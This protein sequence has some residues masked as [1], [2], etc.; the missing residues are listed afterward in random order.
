MRFLLDAVMAFLSLIF[1]SA[2]PRMS[3]PTWPLS[4]PPPPSSPPAP[5]LTLGSAAISPRSPGA[6]TV[7]SPFTKDGEF[8]GALCFD[9]S[10]KSADAEFGNRWFRSSEALNSVEKQYAIFTDEPEFRSFDFANSA[11]LGALGAGAYLF[12]VLPLATTFEM[13]VLLGYFN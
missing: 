4:P 6:L 9:V 1:W 5:Q 8:H 3:A 12:A 10:P 11:I 13:L 2:L 7:C